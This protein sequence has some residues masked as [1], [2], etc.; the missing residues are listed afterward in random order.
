MSY[1][2]LLHTKFSKF[3][4]KRKIICYFFSLTINCYDSTNLKHIEHS[5]ELINVP[6]VY[7]TAVIDLTVKLVLHNRVKNKVM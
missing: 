1:V 3:V 2:F 6:E 4:D 7:A 5:V